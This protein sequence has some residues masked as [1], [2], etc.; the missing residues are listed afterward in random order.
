MTWGTAERESHLTQTAVAAPLAESLCLGKTVRAER[1]EVRTACAATEGPHSC[2]GGLLESER[3]QG[4]AGLVS[5]VPD[6]V[7]SLLQ[8]QL[9]QVRFLKAR[10]YACP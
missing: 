2:G 3:G 1:C 4:T 10:S 7:S 6:T 8:A 9:A 5:S